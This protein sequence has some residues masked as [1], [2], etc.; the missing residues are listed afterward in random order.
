[1][2]AAG[3]RQESELPM[4]REF[5][6]TPMSIRFA[7]H[8]PPMERR[9]PMR[10]ILCASLALLG[11]L[12]V[13][14]IGCGRASDRAA[15]STSHAGAGHAVSSGRIDTASLLTKDEASAALGVPVTSLE[16]RGNASVTYKTA[17]PM[18][19]AG[20]EAE[21]KDGTDD[22]ILA[23]TGARKATSLLGGTPQ[24]A[25]GLGDDAFYGAMSVLYVRSG[26][27]VLTIQPPNLLQVAQGQAYSKVTSAQDPESQKKAMEGFAATMKNDPIQA[28]NAERDPAKAATDVVAASSKPQGTEYEVKARAIAAEIARKAL[29]RL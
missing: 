21:R 7:T 18:F 9:E 26:N 17:D 11:G 4:S 24:E 23:M 1:M 29:T 25:A 27:A 28:G 19:E 8:L 14:G 2:T 10:R 13:S 12:L 20:L 16:R 5:P 22:A 6:T 3:F 15:D